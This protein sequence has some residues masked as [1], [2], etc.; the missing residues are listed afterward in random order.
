MSAPLVAPGLPEVGVAAEMR[1]AATVEV[2]HNI[3]DNDDARG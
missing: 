1:A 2:Q 3:T